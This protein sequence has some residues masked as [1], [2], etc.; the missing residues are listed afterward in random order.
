MIK[1]I[2]LMQDMLEELSWPWAT[3]KV[4]ISL[5]LRDPLS[6]K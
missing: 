3:K 2:G 1:I 6:K 5:P 4:A